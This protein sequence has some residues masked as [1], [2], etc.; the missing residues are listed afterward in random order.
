[1]VILFVDFQITLF[2]YKLD[3]QNKNYIYKI[4]TGFFKIKT[5][6]NSSH[7]ILLIF[8]LLYSLIN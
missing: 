8:K 7:A 4:K 2:T 3:S 5:K 6:K 1:M